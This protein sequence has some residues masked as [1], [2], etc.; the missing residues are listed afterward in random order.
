VPS[1]SEIPTFVTPPAV[2][3]ASQSPRRRELL[4]QIGVAY[5]LVPTAVDETPAPQEAPELFVLRTALA[6]ARSGWEAVMGRRARPVLGADTAVAAGQRILGKPRDRG[7]ALAMLELLAG[8]THSVL[9]GV[10]L[11]G[12]RG[13]ASRLSVSRVRFRPIAP[14]EA[15][16]YWESGEPGD[17]AGAYGIQ[18][19]GAVF[20]EWLEGSYSGVMGLPLFE[21]AELLA[22]AGIP[23]LAPSGQGARA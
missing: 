1:H 9:T 20:V 7:D 2:Y 23:V 14:E 12:P 3:L 10:A 4:A 8:R 6:K 13:E 5:E 21:T 19:L 17:K 15:Q 16:V 18:G 11:C 22:G